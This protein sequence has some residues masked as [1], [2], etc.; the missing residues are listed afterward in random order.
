M[1]AHPLI[2]TVLLLDVLLLALIGK[3]AVKS[4]MIVLSWAPSSASRKQ[5]QLERLAE[6][7]S[8]EMNWA[9]ALSGLSTLTMIVL[10]TNVLPPLVPGAMCGTGVL[11]AMGGRGGRAIA[12]RLLA[13]TALYFWKLIEDLNRT[14]PQAP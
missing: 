13:F 7:V 4:T 3:A 1:M 2:L 5:L 9:L 11:Q 14:C 6:T 10:L 8:V 12:L